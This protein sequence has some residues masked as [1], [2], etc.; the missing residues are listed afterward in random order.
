T[1]RRRT[2]R[3]VGFQGPGHALV[4]GVVLYRGIEFDRCGR[5]SNS[6]A[7]VGDSNRNR[8]GNVHGKRLGGGFG[9]RIFHLHCER[10]ALLGRG[11]RT[12]NGHRTRSAGSESKPGREGSAT[13]APGVRSGTA[14]SSYG[15]CVRR[16][17]SSV[18]NGGGADGWRRLRGTTAIAATSCKKCRNER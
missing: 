11:R 12:R 5:R 1:A 6:R 16:S 2:I 15:R 8:A 14:C 4:S 7:F 17:G 18:G 13:H 10:G 9:S 3:T